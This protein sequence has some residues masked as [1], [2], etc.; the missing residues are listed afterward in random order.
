M[1]KERRAKII[2]DRYL[3]KARVKQVS[4]PYYTIL[5]SCIDF[6]E[7]FEVAVDFFPFN[8][9]DSRQVPNT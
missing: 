3:V 2:R 6:A 4:V 8:R 1:V 7:D 9:T 5:G